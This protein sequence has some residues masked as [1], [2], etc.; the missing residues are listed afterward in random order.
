MIL[1]LMGKTKVEVDNTLHPAEAA[2]E[3]VLNDGT[4]RTEQIDVEKVQPPKEKLVADLREE[5][6]GLISRSI[7][8]E[9]SRVL[10][11][12]VMSLE[13]I[14]DF[15]EIARCCRSVQFA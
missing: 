3:V 10:L 2:V 7:A 1:G 13:G 15:R 12:S 9:K 11:D 6:R 8:N 4:V 5:F 14:R